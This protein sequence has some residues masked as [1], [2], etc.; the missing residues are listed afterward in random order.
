MTAVFEW[1]LANSLLALVLAI[2]A[3]ASIW[4]RRPALTHALWLLVLLHLITPP[5]W[6]VPIAFGTSTQNR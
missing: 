1:A 3:Y 6:H 5:M 2:P 4:L